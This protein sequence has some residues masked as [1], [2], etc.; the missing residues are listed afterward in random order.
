MD[1]SEIPQGSQGKYNQAFFLQIRLHELWLRIDRMSTNLLDKSEMFGI[2]NYE[3]VFNDLCSILRMVRPYLHKADKEKIEDE[4]KKIQTFINTEKI[5]GV[6]VDGAK[7]YRTFDRNK[8]NEL[9]ELIYTFEL[10]I[11]EYAHK[12]GL[13]NPTKSD[14]SRALI[15]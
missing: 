1:I 10:N 8:W 3:V 6:K 13:G 5:N 4:R 15:D 9:K 12:H 14:P 2:Y 7:R 11:E